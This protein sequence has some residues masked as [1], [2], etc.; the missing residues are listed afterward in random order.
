MR[1]VPEWIGANPDSRIPPRVRLRV[2][3]RDSGICQCGCTRLIHAGEKWQTDHKVAL[4]NGGE[5][6]ESNLQLLLTKHHGVKTKE[7]VAEKA[8]NYRKRAKHLGVN[9]PRKK[10]QSRGFAKSAPQRTAS[11]PIVRQF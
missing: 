1:T 3:Y 9:A 5:H 2:F 4:I 10:I 8:R 7:D 11:R 6:R